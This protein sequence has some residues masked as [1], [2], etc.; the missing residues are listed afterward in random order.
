MREAAQKLAPKTRLRVAVHAMD[1]PRR[2][3]FAAKKSPI[4]KEFTLLPW[5]GGRLWFNC[6]IGAPG[7]IQFF[8]GLSISMGKSP[9]QFGRL[10]RLIAVA[11]PY[12]GITHQ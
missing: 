3:A 2:S 12:I 6:N 1:L 11:C 10:T 9:N 7:R 5:M 4:R 8:Q